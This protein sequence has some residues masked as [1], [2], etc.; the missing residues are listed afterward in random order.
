VSLVPARAT[1]LTV[2][3]VPVRFALKRGFHPS[4]SSRT[5]PLIY[6][7]TFG[8]CEKAPPTFAGYALLWAR[9]RLTVTLFVRPAPAPVPGKICPDVQW[10]TYVEERIALPHA[11]GART[12][13]DG[14]THPPAARR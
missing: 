13:Y 14:A 9:H 5:L 8:G 12:L 7:V 4:R 10:V 1:P 6:R 2:G 3:N 11:L